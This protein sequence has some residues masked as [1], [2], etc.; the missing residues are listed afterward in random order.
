MFYPK[1]FK[2]IRQKVPLLKDQET[3]KLIPPAEDA[4]EKLFIDN[5]KD[6]V[7]VDI[8]KRK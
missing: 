1:L 5:I 6:V 4:E 3:I 2:I 8:L 7:H